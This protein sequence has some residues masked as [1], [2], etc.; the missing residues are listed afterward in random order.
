MSAPVFR[1]VH[2]QTHAT[3]LS[4]HGPQHPEVQGLG[5]TKFGALQPPPPNL[6][7][8]VR[9]FSS[10]ARSNPNLHC[11]RGCPL[12][13]KLSREEL[14]NFRAGRHLREHLGG[15]LHSMKNAD[16]QRYSAT[17]PGSQSS[18]EPLILPPFCYVAL[19]APGASRLALWK[20][21]AARAH[22]TVPSL[23]G[24]THLSSFSVKR[25]LVP[26]RSKYPH[27]TRGPWLPFSKTPTTPAS[28]L[29]AGGPWGRPEHPK[30]FKKWGACMN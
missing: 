10:S 18:L 16:A 26:P 21:C 12:T 27:R 14:E 25:S 5:T 6:Q 13:L 15:R 23:A 22:T 2:G 9:T 20:S 24:W 28:M 3:Q 29:G 30:L 8:A 4:S 7:V 1:P 11:P 19:S 17:C